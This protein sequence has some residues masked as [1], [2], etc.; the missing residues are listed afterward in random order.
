MQV[1]STTIF[2]LLFG[3]L[4]LVEIGMIVALV[5][6]ILMSSFFL[7]KDF[8]R[9]DFAFQYSDIKQV[10]KEF[11]SFPKYMILSDISLTTSQQFIPIIFSSFF[12]AIIVGYYSLANRMI[13]L[14]N[15]VLTSSIANVFRNDAIDGIRINGNCFELYKSTF[16]KLVLISLS[17]YI[18]VFIF[19]PMLFLFV[20]CEKW[21]Q[22]GYFARILS[23]LLVVEFIATPLNSLFSI[24]SQQKIF[25]KLQ[26]LNTIFGG[27][28]TYIGYIYFGS[29]YWALI[30]F[31]F[32][33]IVF[34]FIFIFLTYNFS[35]NKIII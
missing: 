12:S 7:L 25:M 31:C 9:T 29:A 35:K 5:L 18:V 24:M 28:M 11:I 16:K 10:A 14:P 34:N 3:Y 19:S 17:I 23:V 6:G 30:F 4:G 8:N 2:S 13:R 20:F 32:S 1:I 21:L 26:L 15:I 22:A 33:T 27:L